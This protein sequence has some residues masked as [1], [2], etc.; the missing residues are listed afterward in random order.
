M[1]DTQAHQDGL[2]LLQLQSSGAP[3]APIVK[4][5]LT[6]YTPG[7][8][9]TGFAEVTQAT[10]PPLDVRSHVTGNLIYE[11]VS[12]PGSKIRIDLD[13]WPE[14]HWPK[15]GGV[16]PVIP[17]NFKAI[18]VLEPDYSAGT[19]EFQ[20]RNDWSGKWTKVREP[21]KKVA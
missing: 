7:Q 4:L 16:G 6:V 3:G 14:I 11:T 15:D 10:N 21:I 19:I 20:Y 2:F 8:K 17:E 9:V 12:G 18:I 13:G 1:A 5:S